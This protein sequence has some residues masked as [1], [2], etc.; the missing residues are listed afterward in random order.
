MLRGR[1]RRRAARKLH[2]HTWLHG[3]PFKMRFQRSRLYISALLPARRSASSSG[4]LVA[5]MGVGGGFLMVPAMIYLLGM[6]TALVV[7]H[8]AVPDHLR[9]RHHHLPA[10]GANHTVDVMLA[11]LLLVGGVVGAQ[12]GAQGRRAPAGRAGAGPAGAAGRRRGAPAGGRTGDAS[13][14]PLLHHDPG[15]PLRPCRN[16]GSTRKRGISPPHCCCSLPPWRAPALSVPP[17]R[18]PWWPTCPT[19]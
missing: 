13:A 16:F 11:L 17:G 1:R 18:S 8:L 15:G 3:L 4:M 5:I 12:F 6:P 19:T 7:G 14:Q 10:G 9:H 2:Q